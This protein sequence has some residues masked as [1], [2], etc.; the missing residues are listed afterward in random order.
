MF[1]AEWLATTQGGEVFWLPVLRVPPVGAGGLFVC[2][3]PSDNVSPRKPAKRTLRFDMVNLPFPY[4]EMLG[5]L[6]S[7]DF[8]P[9]LCADVCRVPLKFGPSCSLD[10]HSIHP[11]RIPHSDRK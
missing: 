5:Q 8:R 11:F 9:R 3:A 10:A 4:W 2:C 7:G 6:W 1:A